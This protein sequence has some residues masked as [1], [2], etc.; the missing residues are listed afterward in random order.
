[1]LK[2]SLNFVFFQKKKKKKKTVGEK[3]RM[4]IW[5]GIAL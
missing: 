1:M 2:L 3:N 4:L 5:H